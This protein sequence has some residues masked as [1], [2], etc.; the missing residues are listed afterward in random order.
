MRTLHIFV[1]ATLIAG[2]VT[3]PAERAAQVER[4]VDEMI[5][6]YGPACDKLGYKQ[7]SNPWRD[8]VLNLAA[9]DNVRRY[10]QLHSYPVTTQCFGHRGFFNCTTF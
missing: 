6:V 8:C 9:Q 1:L 4:E 10:N 5:Q 2:C 3:T 7:E